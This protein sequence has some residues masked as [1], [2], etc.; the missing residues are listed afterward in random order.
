MSRLPN[1]KAEADRSSLQNDGTTTYI[2][3]VTTVTAPI[4]TLSGR[5]PDES[6][7]TD[8][9]GVAEGCKVPVATPI[10]GKRCPE[11][12]FLRSL[13]IYLNFDSIL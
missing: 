5:D 13:L 9:L 1:C 7:L 3:N 2:S 8:T 10:Y 12:Q 4:H 6:L 11:I